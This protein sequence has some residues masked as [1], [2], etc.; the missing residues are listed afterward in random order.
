MFFK[1]N[2]SHCK[3]PLFLNLNYDFESEQAT[4]ACGEIIDLKVCYSNTGIKEPTDTNSSKVYTG[5]P[6]RVKFFAPK[7]Y[8]FDQDWIYFSLFSKSGCVVSLCM[9]P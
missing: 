1:A 7:I 6:E 4:L 2:V 8:Y 5:K 9:S 3:P